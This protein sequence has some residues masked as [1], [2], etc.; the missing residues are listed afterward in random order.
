MSFMWVNPKEI[1]LLEVF[2]KVVMIDTAEKI[3]NEKR[4]LLTAE[5]K[6]SHGNMFIFL[7]LFMPNQQSW[8][9]RW[10]FFIVFPS[11]IP[12]HIL[13]NIKIIIT[14]DDSQE[15][16]QIDNVIKSVIPNA[17]RVRCG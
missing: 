11:L 1:Y 9:F 17:K 4:P 2:P 3:N 14:D 13:A 8:V 16:T 6:D 12:K 7:H 5:G 15:F 10:I